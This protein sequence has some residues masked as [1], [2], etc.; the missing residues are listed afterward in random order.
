[1][2][3][4][5]VGEN[6]CACELVIRWKFMHVLWPTNLFF[7]HTCFSLLILLR[8]TRPFTGFGLPQPKGI[9]RVCWSGKCAMRHVGRW[10]WALLILKASSRLLLFDFFFFG[11]YTAHCTQAST[12]HCVRSDSTLTQVFQRWPTSAKMA[13]FIRKIAVGSSRAYSHSSLTLIFVT[14]KSKPLAS[15]W[16]WRYG[17]GH[18]A[19]TTGVR[20]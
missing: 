3:K 2:N 8:L 9:L 4:S 15:L 18:S 5:G 6:V 11:R 10:C 17:H 1:M 19:R 7:L 16:N 13:I 20:S 14:C 12:W